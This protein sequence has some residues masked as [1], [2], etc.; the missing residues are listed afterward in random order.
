MKNTL[1]INTN[2]IKHRHSDNACKT[3]EE[4]ILKSS[5]LELQALF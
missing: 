5:I 2:Y 3:K 1:Q 4:L